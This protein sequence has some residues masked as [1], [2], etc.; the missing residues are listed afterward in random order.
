MLD[1]YQWR[2]GGERLCC[3]WLGWGQMLWMAIVLHDLYGEEAEYDL[4]KTQSSQ[5]NSEQ[6]NLLQLYI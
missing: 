3:W 1:P 6:K 2:Q 5:A 4:T